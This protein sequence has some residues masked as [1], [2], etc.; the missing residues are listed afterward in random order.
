MSGVGH[1]C[2]HSSTGLLLA[3]QQRTFVV[4]L[5]P[6]VFKCVAVKQWH[7]VCA[8]IMRDDHNDRLWAN[9]C[10]V[11]DMTASRQAVVLLLERSHTVR[12]K[13]AWCCV[14]KHHTG[15]LL[16]LIFSHNRPKGD[17][18]RTHNAPSLPLPFHPSTLAATLV[19]G[20]SSRKQ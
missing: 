8:S 19:A 1:I 4:F 3:W 14:V 20:R 16:T 15:V 9:T 2:L 7:C 11:S 6:S 17:R 10:I 18:S 12:Q 5:I 13:A